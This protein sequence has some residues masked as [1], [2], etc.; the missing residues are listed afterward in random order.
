MLRRGAVSLLLTAGMM[1]AVLL[2][3]ASCGGNGAGTG[4]A[5]A[6]APGAP[7]PA[8][9]TTG[10]PLDIPPGFT[11]STFARGLGNPRVI[12]WDS[13][14]TMLVS[15]TGGGRVVA[16]PDEDRNGTADT[17]VTVAD[18]LNEPHGLAFSPSDPR[19]LYIA[20]TDQ[21]A[22]WDYDPRT[23]TAGNKRKIIDL[24][25]GSG[26]FTRTI[27]FMPAPNE[28]RLLISVGSSC[29]VC[30]EDDWRRAKIL[31]A[32]ADGSGLAPFGSGLR[33]S[34]FM[35][36]NPVTSQVWATENGRDNL[37]DDV[38]P[39]EVNI[40]EEGKDYGWPT[41]YGKNIHDTGFDTKVYSPGQD[42][43]AGK[44]LSYIDLQA[45]SAALGLDFFGSGW[46]AEFGHDL[47]VAFHGSW[48]RSVPTGYKL[49]RVR[50]D[51]KG[52]YLGTEDFI[53]G[54]L[55]PDGS[56]IGRPVAVSI[57]DGDAI[58]ISD[59]KAGLI[60]RVTRN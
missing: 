58:Y 28:K 19:Q 22:I 26:H 31:V 34:V 1:S 52:G 46:P 56:V 40:I 9:N 48:N 16:L 15:I 13:G 41:C 43:C 3:T 8:S 55:R 30:Y 36:V 32:A 25:S 4:S 45:H 24:P 12:E 37:G 17:T 44:T 11:I 27:M 21:V 20:E 54:W 10:L 14:G 49:I 5:P 60:Y 39:D 51:R 50:L 23:H 7:G 57:R 18:G 59:D 33:N 38:P 42:P 6:S 53:T 2:A 29:N 35:A 47:L